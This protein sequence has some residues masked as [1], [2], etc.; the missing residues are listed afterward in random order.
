MRQSRNLIF[1]VQLGVVVITLFVCGSCDKK[2]PRDYKKED[3]VKAMYDIDL[4]TQ[5]APRDRETVVPDRMEELVKFIFDQ[6]EDDELILSFFERSDRAFTVTIDKETGVIRDPWGMP[7][8]LIVES[9]EK[10]VLISFGPNAKDD[11]RIA[12]DIV[13]VF[14]PIGTEPGHYEHLQGWRP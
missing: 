13:Y 10:Y 2:K 7:I 12:D 4:L 6:Y 1:A 14:N 3:I 5:S 8:K 11:H 9:P